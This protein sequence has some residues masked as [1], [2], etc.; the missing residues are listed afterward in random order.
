M[1]GTVVST[2]SEAWRHECEARA[3]LQIPRLWDRQQHLAR[4]EKL[5]GKK[6]ADALKNT[7]LAIWDAQQKNNAA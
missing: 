3:I 2:H 7:M 5:R 4:T 6:T 1:D